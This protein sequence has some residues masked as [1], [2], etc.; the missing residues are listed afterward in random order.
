MIVDLVVRLVAVAQ[1]LEDLHALLERRLV[2]GDLLEAALQRGVALEVLAVLVERRRADGLQLAARQGR[3]ED[4]G[5]VD[6]ALGGTRADEVVELVDEQDDVAALGDLLHHLLEALLELAAVL[7]AGDQRGQVERVDLL[8]LQQLRHVAVGDALGEAL[9]DGGLADARLADQHRVV[10]GAAR[11]DLHDPLDLGLAADDGVELALG[12]Q[13][14]QVAPELVEQLRGLLALALAGRARGGG[15]RALAGAL[16]AAAGP[17]EHADDLVADLLGVGVEVE[18]DAGG[19]ALVLAHE[20]EQD[21]LGAD[22]VVAEGERLAQRQ[23][24]HLL[25]ARRERDLAGGD[26]LTGADDAHDLGAHALDGDVEALEDAGREA[27]LLAQEA[28]QDV[29]GPDVVVLQRPRLLLGEDD[30]LTGSLCESLEHGGAVL[31]S[32]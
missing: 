27:L 23:L 11:E 5:G 4:R 30:H 14:G 19:D 28:E 8:V 29:L 7:R 2:D 16:A 1:A 12:G 9:D 32:C 10:L 24:E 13:L 17:G 3:L 18:E 21:V 20:A 15:T 31:P 25:G 6:R 26:L 22:V